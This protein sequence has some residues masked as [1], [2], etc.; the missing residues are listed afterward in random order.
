[1]YVEMNR[2]PENGA[3]IR[4]YACRWSGIMLRLRT[5]KSANNEEEQQDDIE[6]LPHGK[7]F[8]K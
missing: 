4:N 7:K 1:M 6:K 5:V 3:E 8:L 2:K